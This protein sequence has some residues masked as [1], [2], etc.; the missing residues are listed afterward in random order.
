MRAK[1]LEK[2]LKFYFKETRT[3]VFELRTQEAITR[4][5]FWG[6][7][8]IGQIL[9]KVRFSITKRD[10]IFLKSCDNI[11]LAMPIQAASG[12][13]MSGS[14]AGQ[15]YETF[16]GI[17]IRGDDDQTYFLSND[18]PIYGQVI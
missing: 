16:G 7:A 3:V 10:F 5:R 4:S 13:P 15:S 6:K 12:S 17:E 8:D 18:H 1:N 11:F 9:L 14:L 2:N